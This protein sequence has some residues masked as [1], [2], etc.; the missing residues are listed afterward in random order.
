[1][2][3]IRKKTMAMRIILITEAIKASSGTALVFMGMR[4]EVISR[5]SKREKEMTYRIKDLMGITIKIMHK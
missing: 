5:N 3:I 2:V 1:V 4:T